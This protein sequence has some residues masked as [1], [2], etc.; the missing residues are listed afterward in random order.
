MVSAATPSASRARPARAALIL[1]I[2][3]ALS[4]AVNAAIANI[5]VALGVPASYGPVTLPAYASMTIL[6]ILVGWVGWRA[7]SRRAAHPRRALAVAVPVV[8][9]L[10]FVPD[11][12]LAVL[13]FIPGTTLSAV[14]ALALMHVATAA[15][16][17]P[18]YVLASR[19]EH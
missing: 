1:G 4:I 8:V 19:Q 6:G 9:A 12:L 3:T 15:I 7:I 16:A 17:V 11:V 5:A 13:R 18:A 10:S 2:A 14:I